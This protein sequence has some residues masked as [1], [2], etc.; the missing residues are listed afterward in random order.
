M[1]FILTYTAR[2]SGQDEW[3]RVE[4]AG[5]RRNVPKRPYTQ[6][7]L[8]TLEGEPGPRSLRGQMLKQ[9]GKCRSVKGENVITADCS[10]VMEAVDDGKLGRVNFDMP[11]VEEASDGNSQSWQRE[12]R[13]AGALSSGER[14]CV[15]GTHIDELW[16]ERI[17]K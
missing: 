8:E 3:D 9:E 6:R 5:D 15:R 10:A 1:L 12:E 2:L 14:K 4:R 13:T 16:F 11:L 7:Y 17:E